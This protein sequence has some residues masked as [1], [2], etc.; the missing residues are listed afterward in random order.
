MS[1][2]NLMEKDATIYIAGHTGLVGSALVRNLRQRGF[3]RL[4]IRAHGE[5]DLTRQADV[6]QFFQSER[7]EYVIIAAAR[8][9]G[10][11]ANSA[12]PAQFIFDNLMIS[13]NVIHASYRAGV[14]KLVNLGS[15]CIY[16]KLAPQPLKEEYLMTGPL[17]P[18][19]EAYAVAK[20]AAIKLCHFYNKQ[21]GTNF[22]S[23]MPTNLYGPN[24]NY[25]L[26]NSHVLPA[27]IRKLHDAAAGGAQTVTLWGDGSPLREFLHAD[28]LADALLWLLEKADARGGPDLINIGSGEE[29]S[30]KELAAEIARLFDFKGR[31]AWDATKP[32][33]TPRKLLDSSLL[34]SL[35]W[36]PRVG[37]A[38]GLRTT[39]NDFQA[40]AASAPESGGTLS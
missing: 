29:L 33:G 10:I 25:D 30:I 7:P 18:T 4:I 32:N 11:H 23:A 9:G 20:I 35:G 16:P 8:V 15:S 40:R 28:D 19:N 34:R 3:T 39:I 24:D 6:E 17:E 5:L 31:I 38:E 14:T 36:K 37:L 12:Y 2:E 22:I 27:L 26:N 13:A 1:G 21:Y